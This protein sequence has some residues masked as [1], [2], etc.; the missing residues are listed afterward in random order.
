[1]AL[2]DLA[3]LPHYDTETFHEEK[4]LNRRGYSNTKSNARGAKVVI[5]E[6][7]QF[8]SDDFSGERIV[9]PP[10]ARRPV[11]KD[12]VPKSNRPSVGRLTSIVIDGTIMISSATVVTAF[13]VFLLELSAG[14]LARLVPSFSALFIFLLVGLVTFKLRQAVGDM[15]NDRL[16]Q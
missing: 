2:A 8:V 9:I 4:K 7:R 10:L 16:P 11:T 14:R 6:L 3:T 13:F 15:R 12:P 1:M 5:A